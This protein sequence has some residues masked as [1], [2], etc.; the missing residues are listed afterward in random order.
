MEEAVSYA[1]ASR[2]TASQPPR[3]SSRGNLFPHVYYSDCFVRRF[4]AARFTAPLA[5]YL[6]MTRA[7]PTWV[8][9]LLAVRDGLVR[10]LGM[11]PTRGFSSRTTPPAAVCTGDDFDFFRVLSSD[12]DKLLLTLED[13]HFEVTIE[14]LL[15]SQPQSQS[16][17]VSSTVNP[18][19]MVGKGYLRLIAPFHRAVVRSLLNRIP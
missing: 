12:A 11:T 14:V 7:A 10:W 9:R 5:A 17:Y 8:I 16:V 15:I 2:A 19:T 6:E 18:H 13:R 3:Q 1:R 4:Q